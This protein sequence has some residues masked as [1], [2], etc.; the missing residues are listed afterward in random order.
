MKKHISS[1]K[2]MQLK[3]QNEGHSLLAEGDAEEKWTQFLTK[4]G[5]PILYSF[6]GAV[7]VFFTSYFYL[8]KGSQQQSK[9]YLRAEIEFGQ[10]QSREPSSELALNKLEALM[11]SESALAEKY[12][13]PLAQELI[14]QGKWEQAQPYAQSTVAKEEVI[15]PSPYAE[16]SN[17]SLLIGQQKLQEALS[18]S[19]ALSSSLPSNDPN[20]PLLYVFNL[21][22]IAML[23][24]EL[25]DKEAEQQSWSL[26]REFTSKKNVFVKKVDDRFSVI[27]ALKNNFK[28]REVSLDQYIDLREQAFA[29]K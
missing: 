25:G 9:D 14:K 6:L 16:F 21:L 26:Y 7:F 17:I 29:K 22:Q 18:R 2:K 1:G 19:L 12:Q 3:E 8:S 13:A 24:G 10:V 20:H 28:E 4:W 27:K 5:K 11:A 23:Q 15:F